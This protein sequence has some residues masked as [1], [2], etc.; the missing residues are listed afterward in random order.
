MQKKEDR[1]I[2]GGHSLKRGLERIIG[3][4]EPY[5]LDDYE[6]IKI[7]ILKSMVW[8]DYGCRWELPDNKLKLIIKNDKVVTIAPIIDKNKDV[9]KIQ[10]ISQ[11]HK[12]NLKKIMKLGRSHG[13]Y[14]RNE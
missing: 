13:S 14:K 7:L 12:D 1:F 4:M 8:N 2:F 5:T 6:N 9:T 10:P 11:F 3:K